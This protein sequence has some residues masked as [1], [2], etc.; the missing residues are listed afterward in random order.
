MKKLVLMQQDGVVRLAK[1]LLSY[2]VLGVCAVLAGVYYAEFQQSSLF[3]LHT[4]AKEKNEI[5]REIMFR[6]GQADEVIQSAQKTLKMC[7]SELEADV[8]VSGSCIRDFYK[9]AQTVK[10]AFEL[11]GFYRLPGEPGDVVWIAG[12]GFQS[13]H[14]PERR[15][16]RSS[17]YSKMNLIDLLHEYRRLGNKDPQLGFIR[18]SLD[19]LKG[20]VDSINVEI[21]KDW[22]KREKDS[23][24]K[25]YNT[26][27]FNYA[28]AMG[29][30]AA[31]QAG[32]VEEWMGIKRQ[33]ISKV[34]DGQ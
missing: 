2:L 13:E 27:L 15:S 24:Y 34:G 18:S 23:A 8:S 26:K 10:V 11:G 19:K 21:L 1:E 29:E 28:N 33:F 4:F 17:E 22:F 20:S 30:M 7:Q 14:L 16:Y 5:E 25:V 3:G 12:S 32:V 9:A 6:V 31:W